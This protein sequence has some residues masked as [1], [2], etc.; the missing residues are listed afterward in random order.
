MNLVHATAVLISGQ[1]LLIMGASGIGKSDLALRLL[2]RGAELISD[3]QVLLHVDGG[4][5]WANPP[6]TIAGKLE[7][8]GIGIV[9]MPYKRNVPIK[10]VV[11]LVDPEKEER[12]PSPQ[13]IDMMGVT[14]PHWS[15]GFA[16]PSLVEKIELLMDKR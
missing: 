11:T 16:A 4:S 3:D 2:N 1:G 5:L 15:L 8:R 9:E 14:A 10:A 7:I 13:T 12:L 6:E